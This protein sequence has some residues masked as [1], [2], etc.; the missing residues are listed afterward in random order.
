[1]IV[2]KNKVVSFSYELKLQNDEGESVQ[3]VDK[4]KPL[5]ILFGRGNLL[6]HFEK[7]IEGLQKGDTFEFVL[8]SENSYGSYNKDA[9]AEYDKTVF[10]VDGGMEEEQLEVGSYIPMETEEGIPFN[11]KVI[12]VSGDKVTIDF[13]HPLA[14]KDLFFKGRILDVREATPQEIETGRIASHTKRSPRK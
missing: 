6:E 13:N 10:T 7:N 14:G 12:A 1:M 2:E 9:V 5:K 8:K 3:Q 11:G 4:S